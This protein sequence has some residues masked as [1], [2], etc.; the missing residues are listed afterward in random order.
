[1]VFFFWKTL[2]ACLLMQGAWSPCGEAIWRSHCWLPHNIQNWH[3]EECESSVAVKPQFKQESVFSFQCSFLFV[4]SLGESSAVSLGLTPFSKKLPVTFISYSF[5]LGWTCG[6]PSPVTE[7]SAWCG[8]E[9]LIEEVSKI[10]GG[11]CMDQNKCQILTPVHLYQMPVQLKYINS[12]ATT[13]PATGCSL[14]AT[15]HALTRFWYESA[16]DWFIMVSV[17]SNLSAKD[18]LYLQPLPSASIISSA[19]PQVTRH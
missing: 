10:M 2:K 12:L 1:M 13:K 14:I 6:L 15:C 11:T 19:L 18:N 4:G 3:G 7:T 17:Q 5:C 8:T 9:A 16:S